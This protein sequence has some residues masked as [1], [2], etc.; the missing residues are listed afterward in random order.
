ML[1]LNYKAILGM[2]LPMMVSGFIQSI[3]LIT[4]A[5]LIS[6]YST[7][8]FDAATATGLP[9]CVLLYDISLL[10][11]LL[12]VITQDNGNDDD[13]NIVTP[14]QQLDIVDTAIAASPELTRF[15]WSSN[16]LTF[17]VA[18]AVKIAV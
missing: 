15:P 18:E 3:V 1:A 4:D 8:A 9:P 17:P 5:S 12:L 13:N 10:I 6:R 14:P 2:A 16:H 11:I 7:E